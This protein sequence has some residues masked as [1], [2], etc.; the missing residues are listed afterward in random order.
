MLHFDRAS[1]G[2]MHSAGHWSTG[3]F[4]CSF[5]SGGAEKE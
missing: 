5:P 1:D 2:D 4:L 3:R